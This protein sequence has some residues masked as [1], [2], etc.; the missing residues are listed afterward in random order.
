MAFD[1]RRVRRLELRASAANT[2][3]RKVAE[4]LGFRLEGT[5]VAAYAVAGR[6]DDLVVY[7]LLPHERSGRSTGS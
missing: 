6:V 2:A 7:G 4:R 1:E 5:F 3:S